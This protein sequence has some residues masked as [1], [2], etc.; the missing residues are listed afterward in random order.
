MK[1]LAIAVTG[2]IFVL[3]LQAL[4]VPVAAGTAETLEAEC[5]KQL[6][7]SDAGCECIGERAEDQLNDKQQALVVAMVTDNKATGTELQGQMTVEEMTEAMEF[8]RSA[9]SDCA[10]E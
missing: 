8:M 7:L 5:H 1:T 10:E 4:P 2:A 3:G 9:P 6:N